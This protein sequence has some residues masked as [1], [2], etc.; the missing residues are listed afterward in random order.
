MRPPYKVP[1]ITVGSAVVLI[2]VG[3]HLAGEALGHGQLVAQRPD[4]V[5]GSGA[6]TRATAP[7]AAEIIGGRPPVKA[8]VTAM[9]NEANRPILGSTPARIENEMASGERRVG[10]SCR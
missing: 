3:A 8:I 2:D 9:V 1:S 5:F 10:R 6:T 7:V 4:L